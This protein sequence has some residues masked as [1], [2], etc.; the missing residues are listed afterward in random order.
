VFLVLCGDFGWSQQQN[1]SS[2]MY[3]LIDT[4]TEK[5]L[6]QIVL[7]R[8]CYQQVNGKIITISKGNYIG[9]PRAWKVRQPIFYFFSELFMISSLFHRGFPDDEIVRQRY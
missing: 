9:N 7:K 8:A 5:V 2:G 6:H 4:S 3:V 1:A